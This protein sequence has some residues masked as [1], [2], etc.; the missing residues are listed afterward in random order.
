[1]SIS[2]LM[3]IQKNPAATR[4]PVTLG[5]IWGPARCEKCNKM[6]A[7]TIWVTQEESELP[8]AEIFTSKGIARCDEC[9]AP[10]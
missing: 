5:E 2:A 7:W 8:F 4:R 1:M 10:E 3:Q 6:K 9:G